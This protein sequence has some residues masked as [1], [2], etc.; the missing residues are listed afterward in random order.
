M[1]VKVQF[2]S[3][4]PCLYSVHNQRV[5]FSR[6]NSFRKNSFLQ[7]EAWSR[8]CYP[9]TFVNHLS[10]SKTD[11]CIIKVKDSRTGAGSWQ[12]DGVICRLC[13]W[14]DEQSCKWLSQA[15]NMSSWIEN[16]WRGQGS[17]HPS[18]SH[19]PGPSGWRSLVQALHLQI[20][21]HALTQPRTWLPAEYLSK[22]P[23]C[24]SARQP[25]MNTSRPLVINRP[26]LN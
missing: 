13:G 16:L 17:R 9:G 6:K 15:V 12:E 8:I 14:K 2:H 1:P 18:P 25:D 20:P 4:L 26:G 24:A 5:S 21:A 7:E 22:H 19:W 11:N 23:R 10:V 3:V